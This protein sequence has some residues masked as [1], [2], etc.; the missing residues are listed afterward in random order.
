[1]HSLTR[2]PACFVPSAV[3]WKETGGVDAMSFQIAD[4]RSSFPISLCAFGWKLYAK[5]SEENLLKSAVAK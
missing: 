3:E 1:M 5:R 2:K 4:A